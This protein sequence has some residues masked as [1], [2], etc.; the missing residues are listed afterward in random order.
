MITIDTIE[1]QIKNTI[2]KLNGLNNV[3][4]KIDPKSNGVIINMF[5]KLSG[6]QDLRG[7]MQ[8]ITKEASSLASEKLGIKVI[9]TNLTIVGLSDEENASDMVEGKIKEKLI[10]PVTVSNKKVPAG[11]KKSKEEK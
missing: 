4:V 8:E 10:P 5:A 1:E 3:K 6:D 7:K 2:N 9:K 11:R